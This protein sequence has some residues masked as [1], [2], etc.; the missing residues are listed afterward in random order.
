MQYTDF[1]SLILGWRNDGSG[2]NGGGEQKETITF[3]CKK[4][5]KTCSSPG[6]FLLF[7][8]K[9]EVEEHRKGCSA[10]L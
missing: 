6:I 3:K 10:L 2:K 9:N 1:F 8:L 4:I 7:F 5:I